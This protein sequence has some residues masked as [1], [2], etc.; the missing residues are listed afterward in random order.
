MEIRVNKKE[1]VYFTLKVIFTLVVLGCIIFGLKA[2]LRSD[3]EALIGS[4]SIFFV[5]FIIIWL[6]VLFQKI[7]LVGYLKGNGVEISES[8]FSDI[9][10]EYV[11]MAE[12]LKIKRIPPLFILQQG[13]SL[14]AFAIRFS[15]R[16]YIAIYS[17]IFELV[18]SDVDAV[19]FILGHELGHVKRNHMSK[20]FWTFLSSVIPFLTAAYSRSCEFTCDSIGYALAPSGAK[21]GLLVLASGKAVYKRVNVEAYIAAAEKNNSNSVRFAGI[22]ASHP[23][24]PKRL[25]NLSE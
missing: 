16:N 11:K 25:K 9:H 12:S 5:Y 2:L 17:D 19:K 21:N 18:T 8:Q 24:L 15:G 4:L 20:R 23:F 7:F 6:F 3:T 14:N 1:N 22:C 10:S 13:G